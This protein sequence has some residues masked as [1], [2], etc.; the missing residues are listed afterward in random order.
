M[1]GTVPLEIRFISGYDVDS[2]ELSRHDIFGAV[3]DAVRAQG[4]GRVVLEPRTHLVPPNDGAGH[5]NILRA[6][7]GP[8]RVSGV[9]VVGDFV[10]NYLR[11]LPSELG[12]VT[13]YDPDTG[14]PLAIIDATDLTSARTGAVT[15]LGAR[16][17]AR[18][19]SKVLGHI[20]ARGTAWWN[21]MMLDDLFDLEEIRVTSA[22]AESRESFAAELTTALGKEVQAVA[23]P[24][25]AMAGADIMVEAS[26]L[27]EPEVLLRTEWVT[28]GSL[29]VPYGTVSAVELSL[30]DVMDKVVVDDWGQA[31]AGR[32]GALREH[33]DK[34]LVTR[35]NLHAELGDIVAGTAPGRESSKERILFWH[36]GLATT[37]LA[38]AHLILQRAEQREIGTLLPY[39]R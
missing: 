12:L 25:E 5:F 6:H 32:F 26:R 39:R 36:R 13:I 29:V 37:D 11:G 19:D 14:A 18:P 27:V 15:A 28:P 38:V 24:E 30:T 23:T 34:R 33:I 22:R 1:P 7:L 31:Q 2:L 35:E 21:I 10:T 4:E 16:H 9:K 3:E 8:Q 20:G 17:L